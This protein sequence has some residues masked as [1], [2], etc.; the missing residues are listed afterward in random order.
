MTHAM[1]PRR[2]DRAQRRLK[3]AEAILRDQL[4]HCPEPALRL[5]DAFAPAHHT[6]P[7]DRLTGFWS[8]VD[9]RMDAWF[10]AHPEWTQIMARA[11]D[12]DLDPELRDL[13]AAM[14]RRHVRRP[15]V[16]EQEREERREAKDAI[17]EANRALDRALTPHFDYAGQRACYAVRL[18]MITKALEGLE[19]RGIT[20]LITWRENVARHLM[21]QLEALD[22]RVTTW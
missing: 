20:E 22:L 2:A 1:I 12:P 18:T 6:D 4:E 17:I 16:S 9:R 8:E 15:I 19:H 14:V 7:L 5:L 21:R 10:I 3:P 13:Y 11:E